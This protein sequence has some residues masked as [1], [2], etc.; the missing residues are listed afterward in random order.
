MPKQK[1]G[2]EDIKEL[3]Q[4]DLDEPEMGLIQGQTPGSREEW[5]VSIALSKLGYQYDYQYSMF[6][7]RLTGGTIIDFMV[8]TEPLSTPLYVNGAYWHKKDDFKQKLQIQKIKRLGY[9][10]TPRIIWDY[11]MPDMQS[12]IKMVKERMIQ[13]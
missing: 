7:G 6:G 4:Q 10:R 3:Q 5:R 9:Y 1:P 2:K 12:T 13:P 8:K 11:E